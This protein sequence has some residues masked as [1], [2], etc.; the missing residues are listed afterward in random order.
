MNLSNLPTTTLL[1]KGRQRLKL[2]QSDAKIYTLRHNIF[3]IYSEKL[4][5]NYQSINIH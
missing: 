1:E 4:K 2:R 3:S 5:E